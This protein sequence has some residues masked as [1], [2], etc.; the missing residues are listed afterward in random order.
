MAD[1]H[2]KKNEQEGKE[3]VEF[4]RDLDKEALNIEGFLEKNDV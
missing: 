1:L 2:N 4:F 3:T